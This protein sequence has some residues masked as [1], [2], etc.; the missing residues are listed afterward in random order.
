MS[1]HTTKR[2]ACHIGPFTNLFKYAYFPYFHKRGSV[3]EWC[4][5]RKCEGAWTKGVACLRLGFMGSSP[6]KG[7]F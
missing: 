1:V 6:T 3:A 7:A 2:D 5:A 4:R